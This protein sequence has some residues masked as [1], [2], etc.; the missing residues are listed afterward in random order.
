M[1]MVLNGLS[2]RITLA[3]LDDVV[4]WSATFEDHKRDVDLVLRRLEMAGL[5]ARPSKCNFFQDEI[6][7]LPG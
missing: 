2:Y 7:V 3:Y 4:V 1:D 6:E 5:K